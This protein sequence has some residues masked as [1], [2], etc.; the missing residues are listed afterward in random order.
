MVSVMDRISRRQ[1]QRRAARRRALFGGV[2]TLAIVTLAIGV[3]LPSLASADTSTGNQTEQSSSSDGSSSFSVQSGSVGALDAP[4]GTSSVSWTGNGVGTD[5][6]TCNTTSTD[7]LTP[8][9]A[10]EK[11]WLFVLNQITGVPGDL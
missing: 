11:G 3:F 1:V 8:I 9:P 4:V 10:G 2:A 5:H 6:Q 7:L